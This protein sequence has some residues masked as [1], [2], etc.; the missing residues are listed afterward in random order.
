[1]VFDIGAPAERVRQTG[2][3]WVLPLGLPPGAV[4]D[5]LLRLPDL[6]GRSC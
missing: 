5:A 4:N 2:R 3:G 6:A 1:V